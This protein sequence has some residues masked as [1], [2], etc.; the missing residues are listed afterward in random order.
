MKKRALQIVLIIILSFSVA[1][2]VFAQTYAFTLQ[3]EI[4]HVI[5]ESNG[6][7]SIAYEFIFVNAAHADPLDFVDVGMPN[8]SFHLSNINA[9]VNGIEISHIANSPYVTN[10]VELGL[11]SNAIQPG[12]VGIVRVQVSG[13]EDVLDYDSSDDAYASGV[14]SPT[15][16][17]SEFVSGD[18]D[19]TVVYHLPPGVN[20]NEPR[21][22]RAPSGWPQE[23]LTT[24][25]TNGVIT[26]EW[27]NPNANGYTQYLF[28]ASFPAQYVP[29]NTISQTTIWE[30]LGIYPDELIGVSIFCFVFLMVFGIPI[31]AIRSS[32]KRKFKYLPP[33]I[34]IE[35]HG[36]KRGLTAIE[37]AILL[38][39]PMDIILMMI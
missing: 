9:S 39:Q 12:K 33:K 3:K 31:M 27:H 35:G 14:F 18:T 36:I 16:F 2:P 13:V 8:S 4:V 24:I 7:L 32:Y 20:P 37:A 21:Y 30:R 5:W 34:A 15:W 25:D 11:G 6:T 29:E 17:G 1:V 10:G 26:Y 38:E 19:F 28:G 23:P 22:H